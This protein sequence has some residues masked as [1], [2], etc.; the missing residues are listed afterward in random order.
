MMT[1]INYRSSIAFSYAV[2]ETASLPRFAALEGYMIVYCSCFFY[3]RVKV[4]F[5]F[6]LC[7]L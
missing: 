5:A 4:V 2:V 7:H 6:V 3:A 1:E